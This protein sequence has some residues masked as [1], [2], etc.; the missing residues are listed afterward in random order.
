[1][2]KAYKVYTYYNAADTWRD[3][4]DYH[5]T[6]ICITT[7]LKKAKEIAENYIEEHFFDKSIKLRKHEEGY[8]Y[9]HNPISWGRTII[10]KPIDMV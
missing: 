6:D 9:A 1:M 7:T 5:Y 3:S 8:Y 4:D 2:S 10:I